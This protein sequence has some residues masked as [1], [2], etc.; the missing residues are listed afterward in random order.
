MRQIS[1]INKTRPFKTNLIV[2]FCE[3]FLSNL[4]G[5]AWRKSLSADR[6]IVLEDGRESRLGSGVH[7]LGMNFDL[8]I[9]WVDSQL[10]VVDVRLARRWR[11]WALPRKPARYVVECAASRLGDFR[12]GDQL[13]FENA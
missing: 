11:T 4:R 5:L 13:A 12:I 10:Q 7:M 3:T 9:V 8:T 6:G 1:L 2:D